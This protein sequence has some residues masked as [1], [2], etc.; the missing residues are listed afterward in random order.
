MRLR[1]AFLFLLLLIFSRTS[2]AADVVS[3]KVSHF[4]L[5]GNY[6][7]PA[8]PTWVEVTAHNNL[9]HSRSFT[10]VVAEVSLENNRFPISETV[11]LPVELAASETRSIDVPPHIVSR[12]HAVLYVQALGVE[13]RTFCVFRGEGD[14]KAGS[15]L[16]S[17]CRAGQFCAAGR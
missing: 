4:G 1:P 7:T 2:F 5:E 15:C 10:L 17:G 9:N 14:E 13:G 3:L 16:L 12:M 8:E 6:A 11:T